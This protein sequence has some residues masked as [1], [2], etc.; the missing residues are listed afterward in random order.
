MAIEPTDLCPGGSGKKIK[1]CCPDLSGELQKIGRM[2]DGKQLQACLQHLD[3]LLEK[4]ADRACLLSI[5]GVL[6][7][8][9][10]KIDEAAANAERFR[11]AH[12]GNAVALAESAIV[13]AIAGQGREALNF[14]QDAM[15]VCTEG[16]PGRAYDAVGAVAEALLVEGHWPAARGLLQMQ[17]VLDQENSQAVEV[18]VEMN[19]APGVPLLLKNDA[20]MS[21]PPDDAPWKAGFEEAL[22]PVRRGSWR[23][24]LQRFEALAD[25]FPDEPLLWQHVAKL[26]CWMADSQG[27][28]E[29]LRRFAALT[30]DLESA[31][32]AEATALLLGDDPLGDAAS[33]YGLTWSVGDIEHLSGELTL[34]DH[35]VQVNIDP[36]AWTDED[37]PPPKA[38]FVFLDRPSP[39][40]ANELKFADVPRVLGQALLFGKQT[41]RDARLEVMGVVADGL[42]SVKQLVGRIA[43]DEL[44]G[45]PAVEEVGVVSASREMLQRKWRL[46]QDVQPEQVERLAGEHIEDSLL[47]RWPELKLGAL[48][49][50]SAREAAADEALRVRVLAVI[51][52][53]KGYVDVEVGPTFDFN[54]LRTELGLPILQPIEPGDADIGK[55]PLVRLERIDA[56]KAGDRDLSMAFQRA[57]A[58]GAVGALPR[59]AREIAGR[60]SLKTSED[61][62][63]AC[64]LLARLE[65]DPDKALEYV[66]Q[67]REAA[68]AAGQSSAR[69]DLMELSASFARQDVE[70]INRL[71]NHI[72]VEHM[73]EP[74]VP[75]AVTHL[76][77]QA[78]VLR[79]DGSP[80]MPPEA[81]AQTTAAPAPEQ[82]G[83][84]LWTPDSEAGGSS[85]GG[86]IWTPD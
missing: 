86:K 70:A 50:R 76:L 73:R 29:A 3:H 40:T 62:L 33:I 78:G 11:Q 8:N 48:D 66:S 47:R 22:S 61:Q 85:G 68:E 42:E 4:H 58:F 80:A 24:A 23:L 28:C 64:S 17:M 25:E 77:V 67:G 32:E 34:S 55:L 2:L 31:A 74:G 57:S 69:W 44:G 9:T 14:L 36:T 41:D 20:P 82:P 38:T 18:L 39:K 43:K 65:R 12:P 1:H 63:H 54:R 81:A 7:R 51:L 79:P 49:G 83:G 6:L 35:A 56:A 53:L 59:L 72:Q 30:D 71:L 46:P 10:E 60:E 13:A 19:R 45:D 27:S 15:E 37:T 75:E 84:K 52:V 21:P 5:K 26:R 16:M